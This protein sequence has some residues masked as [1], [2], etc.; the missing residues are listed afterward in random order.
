MNFRKKT[1]KNEKTTFLKKEGVG[2]YKQ[3]IFLDIFGD[4]YYFLFIY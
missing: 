1:N 3:N 4:C 2:F